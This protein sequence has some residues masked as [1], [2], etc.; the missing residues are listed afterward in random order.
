MRAYTA[1]VKKEWLES[2]RSFRLPV[3]GLILLLLGAMSPLAA[4]YMPEIVAGF[5][6]AG[7]SV[8]LSKPRAID[9]WLQFFKNFSQIGLLVLAVMHS[10]ILSA[11]YAKGTLVC[12]LTKGMPRKSVIFA[13]F[14]AAALSWS[15]LYIFSVLVCMGYTWFFWGQ[16]A[17]SGETDTFHLMFCLGGLW[18]LGV[19]FLAIL[20]LGGVLFTGAYGSLLFAG[21]AALAQ[22]IAGMFP[23]APRYVPLSLAAGSAGALQGTQGNS[24]PAEAALAGAAVTVACLFLAVLIFEKRK[25]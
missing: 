18:L 2:V 4:R 9:A 16:D 24:V 17:V 22:I 21:G 6:P 3:L 12:I 13:K 20:L 19:M 1:F 25:I 14:T 11:E 7:M 15:A 10:G 23:E 8:E 5:L